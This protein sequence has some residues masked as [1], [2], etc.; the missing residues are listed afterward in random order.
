MPP[1]TTESEP[2]NKLRTVYFIIIAAIIVMAASLFLLLDRGKST[3]NN[4]AHLSSIVINITK[5]GFQPATIQ[6]KP[7]STVT[8]QNTDTS[9]HQVAGNP[10]PQD[11]SVPGLKSAMI[12]PGGSYNYTVKTTKTIHYHDDTK[13]TV[14]GTILVGT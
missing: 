2:Q 9:P 4:S 6:I 11:N 8:W 14:N 7:G 10:Y 3:V 1:S 13:P 12:L 5:D